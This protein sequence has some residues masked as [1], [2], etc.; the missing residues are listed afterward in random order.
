MRTCTGCGLWGPESRKANAKVTVAAMAMLA[1]VVCSTMAIGQSEGPPGPENQSAG[2]PKRDRYLL[3]DF[4]IIESTENAQLTVGVVQKDK[5]NPLFKE[6]K[7]WE[8]RFDNPYCSVIYDEKEKIYKCWYSIFIKSDYEALTP[9]KRAWVDW[10]E[11]QRGFGV[12]YA[13]SKDG[14]KWEKP[15]LGIIEFQ[16]NKKNNI[17]LLGVHGVGV[18]KD[19]HETDPEKRY[20]AI[21]PFRGHTMVWFSSDGLNWA[22]KKLPGLDDGDTYNCTFWDPVLNKYVLFTRNWGGAGSKSDRYGRGKYR[23]E[24]RS[25]S[26][27]FLNWSPAKIV[28][29][30]L[31]TDLQIHDMPVFR[32]AGVYIGLV[33]L[34]E[35]VANRQ[36]VELAWSPDSIEW[37][38][39]RPGTPLIANSEQMGDYDWGC[40]FASPPIFGKDEIRLYYGGND[41]RFMGWRSGY[42]CLARLRP[43]GFAGYE[44]IA[45]GSNKTATVTTKPVVA[46]SGSLRLSADVAM[47]GYVKVTVLD[48]DN[49]KLAES[50]LI[51]QT[52]TDGEVRWKEGFLLETLKGNEI[53]LRF[54]LRDAKLYSFSFHE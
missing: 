38:R 35:I 44:Q 29:E 23:R 4:R 45:G 26:P 37:H 43:D 17:V 28:I 22:E 54:E 18:I 36:H 2:V 12:C 40:I 41:G 39:I 27:D 21:H 14:I 51:T 6:D 24:S 50:E 32:H 25:E 19:L 8:P 52:V 7:P 20:K 33:G 11:G 3:L 1:A 42:F 16:G 10:H 48:K 49:K 31:D 46:V 9:E 5:Y 13:T 15:E 30:G 34:F 47:S 53:R